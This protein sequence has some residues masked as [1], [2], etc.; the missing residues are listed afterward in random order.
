MSS[1]N[2]ARNEALENGDDPENLDS[3]VYG[4][5]FDDQICHTTFGK[6]LYQEEPLI[7]KEDDGKTSETQFNS[8]KSP[9]GIIGNGF[10]SK[11][12]GRGYTKTIKLDMSDPD[13]F[14]NTFN[15]EI[16][17]TGWYSED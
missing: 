7:H 6:Y 4:Y 8:E 11:Y 10:I 12:D 3:T 17:K 2:I 9:Y 1:N 14:A 15:D 5:P 16:L 13:F